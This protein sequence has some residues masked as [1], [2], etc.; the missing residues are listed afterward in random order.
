MFN[1]APVRQLP[2]NTRSARMSF[3]QVQRV[4]IFAHCLQPASYLTGQNEFRD[5]Q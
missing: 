4:F 2:S 1:L 3:S 5:I